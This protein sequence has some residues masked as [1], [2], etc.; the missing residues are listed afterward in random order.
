MPKPTKNS[1]ELQTITRRQY[2]VLCGISD[3]LPTALIAERLNARTDTIRRYNK[4]LKNLVNKDGT[5]LVWEEK[6]PD[7]GTRLVTNADLAHWRDKIRN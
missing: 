6:H 4:H 3:G 2:E 1:F 5:P 7:G